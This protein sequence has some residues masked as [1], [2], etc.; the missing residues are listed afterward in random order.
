MASNYSPMEW[1]KLPVICGYLVSQTTEFYSQSC[2]Q[3]RNGKNIWSGVVISL[4]LLQALVNTLE[5]DD[6]W[7]GVYLQY[8]SK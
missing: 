4:R 7:L 6:E 3:L 2:H 5:L 8:H 1:Q